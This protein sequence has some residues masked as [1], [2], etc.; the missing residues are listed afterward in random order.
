M[1]GGGYTFNHST[2]LIISQ[3]TLWIV[4]EQGLLISGFPG[5]VKM[6]RLQYSPALPMPSYWL[7]VI[8]EIMASADPEN[9]NCC[10]LSANCIL[11]S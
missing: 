9:A 5:W 8:Q 2:D 10:Q 3:P 7:W 6:V 1:R 11:C 4:L